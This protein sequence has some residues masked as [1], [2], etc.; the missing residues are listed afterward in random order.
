V[1]KLLLEHDVV[2]LEGLDLSAV[3][4]GTYLLVALPLKL[5]GADGAPARVVLVE[6]LL[7]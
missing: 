1:H 7:K 2:I 4:P 5:Q 3:G 6:G